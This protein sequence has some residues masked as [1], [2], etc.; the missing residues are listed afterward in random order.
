MESTTRSA[1]AVR[2]RSEADRDDCAATP[3]P[4]WSR[5]TAWRTTGHERTF[6]NSSMFDLRI[7]LL[8]RPIATPASDAPD[9]PS[10]VRDAIVTKWRTGSA[11]VGPAGRSAAET[12]L[13]KG[14]RT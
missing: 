3:R 10:G 8:R 1:P 13:Q 14:G 4:R 5:P 7:G 6:P 9:A 2:L 12:F 11:A